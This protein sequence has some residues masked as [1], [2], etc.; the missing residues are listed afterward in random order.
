MNTMCQSKKVNVCMF[1]LTSDSMHVH[2]S[3]FRFALCHFLQTI[4]L[5]LPSEFDFLFVIYLMQQVNDVENGEGWRWAEQSMYTESKRG[6][7]I[8][9][10]F[11]LLLRFLWR[12][13]NHQHFIAPKYCL[14]LIVVLLAFIL[15][16]FDLIIIVLFS[17]W[18][19]WQQIWTKGITCLKKTHNTASIKKS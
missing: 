12:R 5:M 7:A 10:E 17:V 13:F 3:T 8:G 19:W 15:V 16:P 1:Y 4:L 18:S 6:R 9:T 14:V 2:R 11:R